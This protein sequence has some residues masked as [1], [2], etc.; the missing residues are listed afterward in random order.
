[1]GW[2]FTIGRVGE[3]VVR[4]HATLLLLLG[5]YAWGGWRVDGASGAVGEFVFVA[6]IFVSILLHE[7]GHIAAARHYGIGTPDVLLTPIGGLA[8]IA[9]MPEEPR[10]E[11]VIA[12]AGPLVTLVLGGLLAGGVILLA[13]SDALF[14][15]SASQLGLWSGLAW[16]NALLLGFN[17]IPA[18]PMDGGRVLRALLASRFG[19]VRGTRIAVRTG[20]VLAVAFAFVGF[21]W[22]IMLVLIAAFVF[23]GAQAELD[24]VQTKHLA[25]SMTAER[26]T[27]TDV[28]VLPPEMPLSAAI[29][30]L[31]R[32]DQ[33]A[34]PVL[35]ASGHLMG[36]LTRDDMLRGVA[37][38]GLAAP[39]TAAMALPAVSGVISV[40]S[41][42]EEAVGRLHE[43]RRD[44]LPVVDAEGHFIGLITRD[45]VT[46]VLLVERL[47]QGATAGGGQA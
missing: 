40:A 18:F 43:S 44:A 15:S 35:D 21:Q 17:L 22:S 13:G 14:P 19:M 9:R 32:S 34:F 38:A 27:V 46:D 6:L 24:A 39:V 7:F 12:L 36:T 4:V 25:G 31:T 42:F 30:I 37:D 47:R 28:R 20:Q 3:T 8:R 5:W 26:L 29:A 11:L 16:T 41:S 2:S 45:N 23:L 1:M 33:R 10:Q